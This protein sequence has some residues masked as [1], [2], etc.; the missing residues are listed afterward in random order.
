MSITAGTLKN[1]PSGSCGC[2]CTL[3]QLWQIWCVRHT[4]EGSS[5]LGRSGLTGLKAEGQASTK[6]FKRNTAT[7][8]HVPKQVMRFE[9]YLINI[10]DLSVGPADDN[11]SFL[12]LCI[13]D[14]FKQ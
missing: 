14:A 9:F 3:P 13:S 10:I 1:F 5:A 11:I 12:L 4:A 6:P 8:Q 7:L 2:A